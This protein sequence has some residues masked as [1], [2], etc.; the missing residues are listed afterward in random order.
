MT[1]TY[2]DFYDADVNEMTAGQLA[3][4][5]ETRLRLRSIP[6]TAEIVD[7]FAVELLA[8]VTEDEDGDEG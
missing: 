1:I 4:L 6:G 2:P 8:N 3:V 7:D 5:L